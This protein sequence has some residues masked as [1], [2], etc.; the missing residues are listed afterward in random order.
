MPV[1]RPPPK[2]W[3]SDQLDPDNEPFYTFTFHYRT[4]RM[5][6]LLWLGLMV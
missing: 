5:V 6:L 1:A 4:R 3:T 2:Y